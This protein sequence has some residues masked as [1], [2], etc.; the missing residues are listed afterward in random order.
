[1]GRT[2]DR[3]WQPWFD[4]ERQRVADE[5]EGKPQHLRDAGS[6]GR[7][8]IDDDPFHARVPKRLRGVP[9]HDVDRMVD[10]LELFGIGASWGGYE[11][12]AIVYPEGGV[13]GWSGGAL[14]RLH[15][16]LE[17]PRDLIAD[18]EQ[19]FAVFG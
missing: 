8:L 7:H 4:I 1:M 16:G 19:G 18:L 6:R 10:R 15:I 17:D 14:V 12:L 3:R 11:S 13:K 2:P 5:H 9:Q